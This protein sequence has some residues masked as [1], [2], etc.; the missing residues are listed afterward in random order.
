MDILNMDICMYYVCEKQN[1]TLTFN[2]TNSS[3]VLGGNVEKCSL[4]KIALG[5]HTV[6]HTHTDV[7]LVCLVGF[8]ICMNIK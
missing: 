6:A 7:F 1:L 8:G 5:K 3:A 2:W 4:L